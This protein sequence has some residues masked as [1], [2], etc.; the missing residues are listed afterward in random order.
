M[1]TTWKDL[2]D[3]DWKL[4]ADI[5]VTHKNKTERFEAYT[6]SSVGKNFP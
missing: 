3:S 4:I 1:S 2:T 6:R 5:I